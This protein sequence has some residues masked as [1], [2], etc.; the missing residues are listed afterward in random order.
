MA[1]QPLATESILKFKMRLNHAILRRNIGIWNNMR[2]ESKTW[3]KFG[4][5][6]A[7]VC[8]EWKV[9]IETFWAE[10]ISIE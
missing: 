7:H 6:H 8:S 10:S 5:S 9:F 3:N 2:P 1:A 4:L